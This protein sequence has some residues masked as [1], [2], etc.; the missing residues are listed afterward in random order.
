MPPRRRTSKSP[1][2][3]PS[4]TRRSPIPPTTSRSNASTPSTSIS[5]S[6]LRSAGFLLTCD[7]PTK[8]FIKSLDDLKSKDK[9]FV[10]E[11]LDET[12]LLVEEKAR[13]EILQKVEDWMNEVSLFS[14]FLLH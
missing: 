12:H 10:I 2:P 13:D 1:A 7:P 4:T 9:K 3:N 8:Q 5:T 14:L 6:A 11:D